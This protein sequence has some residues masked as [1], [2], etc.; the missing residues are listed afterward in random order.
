MSYI[1]NHDGTEFDYA[2]PTPDM[3][4][5]F[6]IALSL[7]RVPR[8]MGKTRPSDC[9]YSVG[10]HSVLGSIVIEKFLNGKLQDAYYFLFH[11]AAEAYICDLPS[12]AKSLCFDYKELERNILINAIAPALN[13]I[14]P[15]NSVVKGADLIMR[16][17]E[18]RDLFD[19]DFKK[20]R[21]GCKPFDCLKIRPWDEFKTR[22][23]FID[24]FNY[25]R[26]ILNG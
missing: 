17:T 13:I 14:Y 26:R 16:E 20:G 8:F 5:V 6:D 12:P 23:I 15:F 25:L 9:M 10:Q 2:N 7:S 1:N 11:D 19:F 18:K 4:T 22:K 3:V 21:E 24:R